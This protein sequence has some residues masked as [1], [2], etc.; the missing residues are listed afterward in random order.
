M[1][2]FIGSNNIDTNSRLCMSSAVAGYKQTLGA[3][4][5][6]ACYEDI[7]HADLI[8]IVGSN[9]AEAH[10]VLFRRIMR[11]KLDN[12]DSVKVINVDPRVSQTSRIADMHLQFK[13]GTDLALL[14]A[15]AHV[16]IEDEWLDQEFVAFLSTTQLVSCIAP[17]RSF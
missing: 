1:K 14:N 5:P 15:M 6:P 11:R 17:Q 7:D 9:T 12:P 4:A 16:I 2:G 8:F 3:D 13:P 10:P